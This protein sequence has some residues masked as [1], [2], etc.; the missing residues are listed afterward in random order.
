[1]RP[2]SRQHHSFVSNPFF[3]Q[4]PFVVLIS[5]PTRLTVDR[6]RKEDENFFTS[7]VRSE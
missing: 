7:V 6:K 1:M 2:L 4:V 3:H 5:C